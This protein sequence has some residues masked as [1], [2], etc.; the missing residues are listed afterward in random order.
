MA[1]RRKGKV[2]PQLRKYLFKRRGTSRRGP[3]MAKRRR[4]SRVRTAA[5]RSYRR[6]RSYVGSRSAVSLTEVAFSFGYG[7]VRGS[8]LNA[9]S[10]LVN[11]LPFGGQYKDNIALGLGAY[12]VGWALK[13]S[14]VVKQALNTIIVSEAFIAGAKMQSGATFTST[15]AGYNG[16]LLN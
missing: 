9:A 13:P 4:Y 1:K 11:M 16:V 3:I 6:A 12:V 2:P 15:G 10:P 8:V 14:G 5:R 7:Y